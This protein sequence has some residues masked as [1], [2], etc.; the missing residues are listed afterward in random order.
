[1]PVFEEK[2]PREEEE[3]DSDSLISWGWAAVQREAV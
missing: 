2:D 1:M 3:C